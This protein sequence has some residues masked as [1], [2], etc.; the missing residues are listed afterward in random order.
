MLLAVHSF[1]PDYMGDIRDMEIGIIFD[2]Q[3]PSKAMRLHDA[4]V[5]QGFSVALNSPYSGMDG[6]M[7]SA[8]HH[9]RGN[10]VDYL[11]LELRQDLFAP[12]VKGTNVQRIVESIV[13][14]TQI[15]N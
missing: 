9:G 10:G 5:A 3:C 6:Q 12:D 1:T 4:F 15:S 14:G 2:K 8:W 7:Y 13:N 11:E